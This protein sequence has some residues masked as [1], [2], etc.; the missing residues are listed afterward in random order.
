MANRECFTRDVL[1]QIDLPDSLVRPSGYH[2]AL[3]QGSLVS[4]LQARFE[5]V[6]RSVSQAS[7]QAPKSND[8]SC[9][10]ASSQ[11]QGDDGGVNKGEF[12]GTLQTLLSAGKA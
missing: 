7:I 4:H 3:A 6:Q 11:R 5:C 9:H 10:D 8:I 1:P 2:Y 12:H